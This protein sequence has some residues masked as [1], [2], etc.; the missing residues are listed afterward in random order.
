MVFQGAQKHP[1][2]LATREHHLQEILEGYEPIRLAGIHR[3]LSADDSSARLSSCYTDEPTWA[4][5]QGL[6]EEL[7]SNQA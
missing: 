2:T 6:L 5:K 1:A 4:S 3:H 7:P